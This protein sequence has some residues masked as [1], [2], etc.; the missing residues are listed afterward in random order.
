MDDDGTITTGTQPVDV[1]AGDLII[2]AE[3]GYFINYGFLELPEL[4]PGTEEGNTFR[5]DGTN[6]VQT[7]DLQ[8]LNN[9]SVKIDNGNLDVP[10]DGI[11]AAITVSRADGTVGDGSE[12][13]A[14]QVQ[15]NEVQGSVSTTRGS[16]S[17][18]AVE[19]QSVRV[20]G[21]PS[22]GSIGPIA[23]FNA[24]SGI[25]F[26]EL[27]LVDA[28][29]N[30]TGNVGIGTVSPATELEV[31]GDVTAVTFIGDLDGTASD[32]SAVGG[33]AAANIFRRT[34]G[35]GA[36]N[37]IQVVDTLPGTPDANTLYFVT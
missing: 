1:V 24:D 22:G 17:F 9:G 10:R 36:Y 26:S 2:W 23:T 7:T 4:P 19:G 28:D 35:T 5:W 15:A 3:E 37:A 8:V 33:V 31:A 29:M 11:N 32:S 16:L 21:T 14:L 34:G 27:T 30:V 13:G 25:E 20:D 18:S 6:W 12:G